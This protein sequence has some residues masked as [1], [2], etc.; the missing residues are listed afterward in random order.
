MYRTLLQLSEAATNVCDLQ[1]VLMCF[2]LSRCGKFCLIFYHDVIDFCLCFILLSWS[3]VSFSFFFSI[4][5]VTWG[6]YHLLSASQARTQRLLRPWVWMSIQRMTFQLG[7]SKC[8]LNVSCSDAVVHQ[9]WCDALI[10]LEI[11]N[12]FSAASFVLLS[13]AAA[14]LLL[15]AFNCAVLFCCSILDLTAACAILVSIIL[16]LVFQL[17]WLRYV[18]LADRDFLMCHVTHG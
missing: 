6:I 4:I 17:L 9:L 11:L 14:N 13:A 1:L 7:W 10:H 3:P 12:I 2:F 8:W 16:S 5:L 15:S 18:G